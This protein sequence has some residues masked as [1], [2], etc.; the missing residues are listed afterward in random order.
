M[1]VLDIF[2]EATSGKKLPKPDNLHIPN[3]DTPEEIPKTGKRI[4]GGET[5]VMEYRD[6][7][8]N[9]SMRRITV[10]S[11]EDGYVNAWCHERDA[12]RTFRTDRVISLA[13]LDGEVFDNLDDMLGIDAGYRESFEPE[14]LLE[15]RIYYWRDDPHTGQFYIAWDDILPEIILL[16]AIARIDGKAHSKENLV[17][18]DYVAKRFLEFKHELSEKQLAIMKRKVRSLYPEKYEVREAVPQLNSLTQNEIKS[19]LRCCKEII[20]ADGKIMKSEVTL[21][22]K[23]GT[24]IIAEHRVA[25]A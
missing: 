8:G 5:F 2:L 21:F 14:T 22:E 6:A 9:E 17:L 24:D 4:V 13:T 1:G 12:Y 18:I 3:Q 25:N 11:T 19:F 23:L 20:A 7:A 10:N 16:R 15:Q